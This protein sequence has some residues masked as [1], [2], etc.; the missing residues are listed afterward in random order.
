VLDASV[1]LSY[2]L[3]DNHAFNIVADGYHIDQEDANTADGSSISVLGR[4]HFFNRDR[5]PS[6][7]TAGAA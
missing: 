1:G 7:L 3:W 2:Y 6:T 4:Y 5:S